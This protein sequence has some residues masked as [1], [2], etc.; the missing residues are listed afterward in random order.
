MGVILTFASSRRGKWILVCRKSRSV[1]VV[2]DVGVTQVAFGSSMGADNTVSKTGTC[3]DLRASPENCVLQDHVGFHP[4]TGAN[5]TE[6]GK[7]S[8]RVDLRIIGDMNG[9]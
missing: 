9:P 1:F 7:P 6:S 4:A 2:L 8:C 3:S 5:R